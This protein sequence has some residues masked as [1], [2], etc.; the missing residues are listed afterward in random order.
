ML[1]YLNTS[2][3][4]PPSDWNIENGYDKQI[5]NEPYPYR[6]FGTGKRA[7]FTVVMRTFNYDID[8]LCGGAVQG[9]KLTFH[10]PNEPPQ[11]LKRYFQ[12]SPGK[13]AQFSIM[14]RLIITSSSVQKY[15][16]DERLCF[17]GHERRLRFYKHYTQRNCEVECLTNFT[18]ASCGCVQFSMPCKLNINTMLKFIV[19]I[20]Q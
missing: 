13:T 14:P 8:H 17:F 18:L 19:M 3:E 10:P 16:P 5:K 2:S 11:V 20:M 6:V 15:D 9:F 7:S 1:M 4:P 12:I